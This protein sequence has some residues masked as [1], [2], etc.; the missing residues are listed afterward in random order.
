MLPH[1]SCKSSCDRVGSPTAVIEDCLREDKKKG[2][3]QSEGKEAIE[4]DSKYR[5]L[6]GEEIERGVGDSEG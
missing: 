4:N 5:G 1:V 6:R 2:S 3:W